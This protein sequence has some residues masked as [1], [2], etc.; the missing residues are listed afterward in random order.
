[1]NIGSCCAGNNFHL[2]HRLYWSGFDQIT[3]Q[4]M[5]TILENGIFEGRTFG[6]ALVSNEEAMV[7][8]PGNQAIF[9]DKVVLDSWIPYARV[10]TTLFSKFASKIKI[11]F[12]ADPKVFSVPGGG[13]LNTLG[14]TLNL[15]SLS[16]PVDSWSVPVTPATTQ[17]IDGVVR[18]F[19]ARSIGIVFFSG[20]QAIAS[21]GNGSNLVKQ[22]GGSIPKGMVEADLAMLSAA[23]V[24][25][26]RGVAFRYIDTALHPTIIRPYSFLN[27]VPA[28]YQVDGSTA[29]TL[30]LHASK[31]P[32]DITIDVPVAARLKEFFF[33]V[34]YGNGPQP[35][36]FGDPHQTTIDVRITVS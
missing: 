26:A 34:N 29:S 17:T 12:S 8:S 16:V 5:P 4:A 6:E 13:I 30:I 1:M 21:V 14:P 28:Q 19:Q 32:I 25:G 7:K 18:Y 24:T 3:S 2:N 27:W 10:R 33:F 36:A 20:T 11:Q 9:N 31:G 23:P 22:R 15:A 35:N